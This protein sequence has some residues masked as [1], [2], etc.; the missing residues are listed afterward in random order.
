MVMLMIGKC[1]LSSDFRIQT[2]FVRALPAWRDAPQTYMS[3]CMATNKLKLY[4]SKSVFVIIAPKPFYSKL[5][6]RRP[7]LLVQLSSNH[8]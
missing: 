7:T 2:H 1:T 8:L 5:L 6:L 3:G 4:D